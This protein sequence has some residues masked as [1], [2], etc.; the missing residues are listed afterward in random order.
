MIRIKNIISRICYKIFSAVDKEKNKEYR[1]KIDKGH[2]PINDAIF[3][4]II[5]KLKL[6]RQRAYRDQQN[7]SYL[8]IGCN[9]G[10]ILKEIEGGTGVDNSEYIIELALEQG[11]NVQVADALYLPF[12]DNIFDVAILSCVLEQ[13]ENWAEVLEEAKRVSRVVIGINPL[14]GSDWGRKGGYVKSI[15]PMEAFAHVELMADIDKY[16]FEY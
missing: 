16:Y 5:S 13:V 10:V 6:H 14:P 12:E 15:I 11:L 7:F 1:I 2:H 3:N 9:I 8:D 4:F